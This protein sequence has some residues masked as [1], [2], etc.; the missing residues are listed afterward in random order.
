VQLS[1][2][3]HILDIHFK[4]NQKLYSVVITYYSILI[5]SMW[6]TGNCPIKQTQ[7]MSNTWQLRMV[8]EWSLRRQLLRH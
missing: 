8:L 1:T 5:S 6:F 2:R 3:K 4:V 7:S